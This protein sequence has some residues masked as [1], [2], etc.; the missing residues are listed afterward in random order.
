M[1]ILTPL[2]YPMTF[3]LPDDVRK[4]AVRSHFRDLGQF[5]KPAEAIAVYS[6]FHSC[7]IVHFMNKIPLTSRTPWVV[8]FESALPRVHGRAKILGQMLRERILSPKCLGIVAM[9]QWA[10]NIFQRENHD[11]HRLPEAMAK[12]TLI[13]PTVQIRQT[14]PRT[15]KR[16]EVLEIAFVGNNFARKGGIV[17]LRLA[18]K[19]AAL[20][21]KIR[22]HIVSSMLYAKGEH[23][24]HPDPE[25]Y[26]EDLKSMNLENVS[27][28]GSLPNQKV[29]QIL[30][31]CHF[32]L[33]ATL[34]DTFGFS[35]LEGFSWGLPALA[36]NVC[37]LPEMVVAEQ[38]G[39]VLQ[40][41][42]D[43]RSCWSGLDASKSG[44]YWSVVS[45]AYES[46]SDQALEAVS[47]VLDDPESLER[48]S[49]GAI[50]TLRNRFN[51]HDATL[52]LEKIYSRI[53][54]NSATKEYAKGLDGSAQV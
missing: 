37:A 17:A 26:A 46:M 9:S 43:E 42:K 45:E 11:W 24:D 27:F 19:A 49:H 16:N 22:V 54:S 44:D 15:L 50:E 1:K 6:P 28:H 29:Q 39:Y 36:T 3:N 13:Y 5:W 31:R 18:K 12:L 30:E 47:R 32:H 14:Q 34:H 21:L 23:T 20:G 40:L 2:G 48:L 4:Y 7:Q 8:T 53:D 33:L 10:S 35:V 52:A 38:N 41:P 25:R 51:P